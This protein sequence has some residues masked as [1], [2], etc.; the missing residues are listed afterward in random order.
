MEVE[1]QHEEECKAEASQAGLN[2]LCG[3]E[4]ATLSLPNEA[5]QAEDPQAFQTELSSIS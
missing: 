5:L 3:D 1:L 2:F 4:I